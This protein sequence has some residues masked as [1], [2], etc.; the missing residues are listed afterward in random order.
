[1]VFSTPAWTAVVPFWAVWP[2]EILLL[3]SRRATSLATL[4]G[5][6]RDALAGALREVAAR[7]DRLFDCEFPYTMGIEQAP[8]DGAPHDEWRLHM[9]F[10][11]PLL[12]SA[13]VRKFYVGYELTGEAQRDV[14][15]EFAA[16]RLRE[17]LA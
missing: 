6:E 4:S 3:P 5:E 16:R 1:V 2:F 11:P 12:R 8:T 14:T 10:L 13:T 15:P 17:A 9:T 7:Y